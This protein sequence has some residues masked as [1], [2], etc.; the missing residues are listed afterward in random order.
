MIF[1]PGNR[2]KVLDDDI[3]GKI[4]KISKNNI[5][6]LSDSDG[7]EYTYHPGQLIPEKG[8]EIEEEIPVAHE[9]TE[10]KKP[11]S[12]KNNT[13]YI[14][15]EIDLHIEKLVDFPKYIDKHKMLQIQLDR[16]RLEIEKARD[17]QNIKLILI[18][19]H[20]KGVL[21]EELIK[22]LNSYLGVE[23]YD[24][25]FRKYKMGAVE[26]IFHNQNRRSN[27]W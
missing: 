10:E 14:L 17:E 22:L 7:F 24:A 13:G 23:F 25:P 26:V 4:L 8:L 2:V 5:V 27:Q 12:I 3:S 16:A 1:K 11:A 21:R 15:R 19:G 20:G 18:H 6:I 9:N